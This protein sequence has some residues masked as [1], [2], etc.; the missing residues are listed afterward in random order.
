MSPLDS[1][2]MTPETAMTPGVTV[3]TDDH[4]HHDS[5]TP[6]GFWIYLMSDCI[7]FGALFATYAVLGGGF[8]GGPGPNDLFGLGSSPSRRLCCCSPRSPSAS[9]CFRQTR[10]SSAVPPAG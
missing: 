8:A 10:A 1:P 6:I 5:P 3:I 2:T 9:P 4:G 7:I